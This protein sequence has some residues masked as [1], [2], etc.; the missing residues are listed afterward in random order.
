M[1]PLSPDRMSNKERLAII[2]VDV[3]SNQCAITTWG[4]TSAECRGLQW[5]SEREGEDV[6]GR[7]TAWAA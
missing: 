3:D 4:Q 1:N 2:V 5:W 6:A 7:M